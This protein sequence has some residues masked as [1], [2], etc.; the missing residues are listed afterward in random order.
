ME[1]RQVRKAEHEQKQFDKLNY[2]PFTHGDT[3]EQ[4]RQ[5]IKETQ[6]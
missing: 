2:F 5:I 3:I 6:K 1:K 4:Q